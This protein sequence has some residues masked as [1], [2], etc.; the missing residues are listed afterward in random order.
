MADKDDQHF[1]GRNATTMRA[2]GLLM[3]YLT[4]LARGLDYLD[5]L[6]EKT[7]LDLEFWFIEEVRCRFAQSR[8]ELVAG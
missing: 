7:L 4:G 8:R 3:P 6:E 5:D 2:K 1:F